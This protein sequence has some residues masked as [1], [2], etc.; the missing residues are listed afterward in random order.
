VTPVTNSDDSSLNILSRSS[1]AEFATVVSLTAQSRNEIVQTKA[2]CPFIASAVAEGRLSVRNDAG[3]PLARIED[4]RL[5]GNSGG[6][7]LGDLLVTF[8]AGNH[9]LMRDGSN[10]LKAK[11]P[12]GFFSLEFPGS[13]GSHFG[14]SAIL[15]ADPQ[16]L[17]S[18]RFSRE[19][20]ERLT[21]K[22]KNGFLKRS[23][24]GKFIAEN[25][26]GDPRSIVFGGDTLRLL[27][28]DL[29]SVVESLGPALIA[30]L[31][32]TEEEVADTH[33][34]EQQALT[35]L[36]GADSL[37]GSAGEFGLLFAFLANA[38]GSRIVDGEPAIAVKDVTTMFVDKKLPE[39]SEAWKKLRT[40]WVTNTAGLLVAAG[41]EYLRLSKG[42]L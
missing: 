35:K 3:N 42:T 31:T 40:D 9:A 32:G 11:V 14:H 26:I 33:R 24:V 13:Q 7:D 18:G 36:A 15:Q 10:N 6:G 16:A 8:A 17:G 21:A 34:D 4:V 27:A 23:D 37:V 39:G 2:T 41:R 20:F 38:P 28:S 22:S 29:L 25:L 30:R 5:L 19:N 12:I 1:I